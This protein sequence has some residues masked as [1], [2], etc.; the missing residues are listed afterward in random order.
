MVLA[1]RVREP[2]AQDA[3]ILLIICARLEVNG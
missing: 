2:G 3:V 1:P